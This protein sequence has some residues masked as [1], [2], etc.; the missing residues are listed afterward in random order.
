VPTRKRQGQ[1]RQHARDKRQERR[2][3]MP[4]CCANR[5]C[6]AREKPFAES[7]KRTL[8]SKC[9]C[10]AHHPECVR[11]VAEP[12]GEVEANPVDPNAWICFKCKPETTVLD[13]I[14]LSAPSTYIVA[15]T[16]E[17]GRTIHLDVRRV[18]DKCEGMARHKTTRLRFVSVL[19]GPL[20]AVSSWRPS[21]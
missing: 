15:Y 1:L 7:E 19:V 6:K 8:C 17:E 12:E 5:N 2:D 9:K 16:D 10:E 11:A 21:R 3:P 20:P 18:H 13:L 14:D 4:K